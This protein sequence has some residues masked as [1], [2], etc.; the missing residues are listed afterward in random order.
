MR[1][2]RL[3]QV[4]RRGRVM[5]LI[6]PDN[7]QIVVVVVVRF[8]KKIFLILFKCDYLISYYYGSR[9]A[10]SKWGRERLRGFSPSFLKMLYIFMFS[11]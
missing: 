7:E 6:D 10:D 2:D 4:L 8:Y 9:D 3:M 11:L 5:A 1:V